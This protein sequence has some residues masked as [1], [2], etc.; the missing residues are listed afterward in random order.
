MSTEIYRMLPRTKSLLGE[1]IKKRRS[2]VADISREGA[3]LWEGDQWH[4]TT[5]REQQRQRELAI[6]HLLMIEQKGGKIEALPKPSQNTQIEVGHMVKISLLDDPDIKEAEISFSLVHVLTTEDAFYL[7]KLFDN[8]KEMVVSHVSSIGSTLLG[9]KRG[10]IV[11]YLPGNRLQ[12]LGDEDA[13]RVSN[14]FDE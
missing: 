9:R 8:V 12:V 3:G 1:D 7:G 13:I 14:L 10:E 6:R 5:Y 2:T 4:S 11:T